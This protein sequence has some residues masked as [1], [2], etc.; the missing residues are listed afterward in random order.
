VRLFSLFAETGLASLVIASAISS[1]S[2]NSKGDLCS[3]IRGAPDGLHTSNCAG[4]AVTLSQVTTDATGART[5]FVFVISCGNGKSAHGTWSS[6]DGLQ[7]SDGVYSICDGGPCTP[8]SSSECAQGINCTDLGEC[9]YEDGGCV[10]T[11]EGC[12]HSAIPCGLSGLC[13]MGSDGACVAMS[14]SDCQQTCTGCAF[15]G[16]C[17]TTGRCSQVNGACVANK[18]SDCKKSEQCAFAGLCTLQGDACIAS[19]DA[20]CTTSEVCRT[21]GQCDAVNGRCGVK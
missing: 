17:A 6:A 13:H 1:C 20:D 10:L 9:G 2:S 7:C 21:A 18:D 16:P 3:S 11:D 4:G 19:T 14:D 12:A 5:S 15:K 8:M